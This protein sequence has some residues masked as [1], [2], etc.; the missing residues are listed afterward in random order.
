MVLKHKQNIIDKFKSGLLNQIINLENVIKNNFNAKVYSNS[1][2]LVFIDPELLQ[3]IRFQSRRNTKI[4]TIINSNI[5]NETYPDILP[6]LLTHFKELM[7]YYYLLFFIYN[8]TDEDFGGSN[9]NL[10]LLNQIADNND[11][12]SDEKSDLMIIALEHAFPRKTSIGEMARTINLLLKR[13]IDIETIKRVLRTYYNELE[14]TIPYD[15]FQSAILKMYTNECIAYLE[16]IAILEKVNKPDARNRINV[17]ITAEDLKQLDITRDKIRSKILRGE[18]VSPGEYKQYSLL[19]SSCINLLDDFMY[20]QN[21][22]DFLTPNIVDY[23][24]EKHHGTVTEVEIKVVKEDLKEHKVVVGFASELKETS[25]EEELVQ[26][27][28]SLLDEQSEE[29][30][31]PFEEVITIGEIEALTLAG[32]ALLDKWHINTLYIDDIKKFFD[33]ENVCIKSGKGPIPNTIEIKRKLNYIFKNEKDIM[34]F[35]E[36]IYEHN[37]NELKD[38]FDTY[39]D[40]YHKKVLRFVNNPKDF[41]TKLETIYDVVEDKDAIKKIME[42]IHNYNKKELSEYYDFDNERVLKIVENP[43]E[44]KEKLETIIEDHHKVDRIMK[45]ILLFNMLSKMKEKDL[46]N[47]SEEDR[48]EFLLEHAELI[49]ENKFDKLTSEEKEEIARIKELIDNLDDDNEN[50]LAEVLPAQK[51]RVIEPLAVEI[52]EDRMDEYKKKPTEDNLKKLEEA[53]K[54]FEEQ[55]AKEKDKEKQMNLIYLTDAASECLINRDL[56]EADYIQKD[57]NINEET[58]Y[59]LRKLAKKKGLYKQVYDADGTYYINTA[60]VAVYYQKGDDDTLIIVKVAPFNY[61]D[62]YDPAI[63]QHAALKKRMEEPGVRE[64]ISEI[65][66][67]LA[68]DK[69]QAIEDNRIYEEMIEYT[70]APKKEKKLILKRVD[71]PQN[72]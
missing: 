24:L 66:D 67:D 10:Y 53:V 70:L 16:D 72:S 8:D 37:R 34:S 17:D 42:R 69:E 11:F 62:H 56:H 43:E 40:F 31:I 12:S 7:R 41:K 15:S 26:E 38:F 36:L 54:I 61:Y 23:L 35:M 2:G 50:V 57:K 27:L 58:N 45:Q 65:K 55:I 39:Y 18:N 14:E 3:R 48:K 29:N 28:N 5:N 30:T 21:N 19:M 6:E 46:K 59:L 25:T 68:A 44:Y 20:D 47:M 51:E 13:N 64:R 60:N 32:Y 1:A 49:V 71:Y 52:I 4:I 63:D 33:F 22:Y 9:Y